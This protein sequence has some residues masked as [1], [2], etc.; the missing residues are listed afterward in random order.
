MVVVGSKFVIKSLTCRAGG[1][2][3]VNINS[4]VVLTAFAEGEDKIENISKMLMVDG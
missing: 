1:D 4:G 2:F 3:L